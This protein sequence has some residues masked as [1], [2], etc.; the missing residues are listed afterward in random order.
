MHG[1]ICASHTLRVLLLRQL[2]INGLTPRRDDVDMV[3]NP[4]EDTKLH[5][6]LILRWVFIRKGVGASAQASVQFSVSACWLIQLF[7]MVFFTLFLTAFGLFAIFVKGK[8]EPI[9]ALITIFGF[10][11]TIYEI[12]LKPEKESKVRDWVEIIIMLIC[13]IWIV[14]AAEIS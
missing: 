5:V 2:N 6:W 14:A 7:Y 11:W 8:E 1:Y 3:E 13:A 4:I 10:F 9:I 12:F